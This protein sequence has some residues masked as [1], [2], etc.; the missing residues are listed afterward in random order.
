L[1]QEEQTV[2]TVS[3]GEW[4]SVDEAAKRLGMATITVRRQ[5]KSGQLTARRVSKSYGFQWEVWIDQGLGSDQ[6]EED[7]PRPSLDRERD[8]LV[9]TL[10][11]QVTQLAHELVE[12][13][14]AAAL[15]QGRAEILAGEL[16]RAR[17]RILLLEA[18]K[19]NGVT[20]PWWKFWARA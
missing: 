7:R 20:H 3:S 10:T 13:A 16:D 5:V 6:T 1:E 12:K 8:T 9:L 11:N 15:W 18:P 17:D 14:E 2:R 19:T 4:V